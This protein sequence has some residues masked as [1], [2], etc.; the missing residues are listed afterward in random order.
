VKNFF[1]LT[2]YN[3][4]VPIKK[5]AFNS[6]AYL[7]EPSKIEI[8]SNLTQM[9]QRIKKVLFLF[10][11]N[12]WQYRH[13]SYSQSLVHEAHRWWF[14]HHRR[15]SLL[16]AYEMNYNRC[17]FVFWIQEQSGIIKFNNHELC[18]I[19]AYGTPKCLGQTT[20]S[21]KNILPMTWF[22]HIAY[23]TIMF[24]VK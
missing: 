1:F 21:T 8:I 24:C 2:V 23:F 22:S 11:S 5:R 20:E 14:Q 17:R 13:Q 4:F 18:N 10:D 12:G 19:T 7:I 6:Q 15:T 16:T 3:N 9:T